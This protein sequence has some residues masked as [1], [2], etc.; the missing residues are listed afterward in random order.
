MVLAF[1]TPSPPF[2]KI[3]NVI[4]FYVNT[5]VVHM[6]Y[7]VHKQVNL[8]RTI[9]HLSTH[10]HFITK[11]K[12]KDVEQMKALIHSKIFHSSSTTPFTIALVVSQTFFLN[13]DST[14]ML[15]VQWNLLKE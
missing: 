4:T 9:I 11:G 10:L 15:K 3:C 2:C 13:T 5:C 14:K 7:V 12:Y 8:T 6:Y 1:V